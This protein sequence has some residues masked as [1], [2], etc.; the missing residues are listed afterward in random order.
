MTG[1]SKRSAQTIGAGL[2]I[3]LLELTAVPQPVAA[4]TCVPLDIPNP[5][6]SDRHIEIC[7]RQEIAWG[8]LV[9]EVNNPYVNPDQ[10]LAVVGDVNLYPDSGG[11]YAA[12]GAGLSSPCDPYNPVPGIDCANED[13]LFLEDKDV[14]DYEADFSPSIHWACLYEADYK[15]DLDEDDDWEYVQPGYAV[16]F[17][18]ID[19]TWYCSP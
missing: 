6:G 14:T 13:P 4:K 1:A 17:P 11:R 5:F 18:A 15:F 10:V 2:L 3:G 7:Y 12:V 9:E 8:N 16:T 19:G